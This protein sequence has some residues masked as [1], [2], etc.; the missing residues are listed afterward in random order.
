MR[1]RGARARMR[2]YYR[3]TGICSKQLLCRARLPLIFCVGA[4]CRLVRR[5]HD[6]S[7]AWLGQRRP[8]AGS[9][10]LDIKAH[11]HKRAMSGSSSWAWKASLGNR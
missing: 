9:D 3:Y 4:L 7:S 6:V 8:Y 5:A 11:G 1:F 2:R 10:K